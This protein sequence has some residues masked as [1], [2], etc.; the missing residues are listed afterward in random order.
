[1]NIMKRFIYSILFIGVM[2]ITASCGKDWLSDLATNPNQPSEAPVQLLLPPLL[3]NYAAQIT[4]GYQSVGNWMGYYA[5]SGAYSIDFNTYTYY[6]TYTN[7]D[8][9]FW[10]RQ[11]KNA[12]YI[13]QQSSGQENME[14]FVAVAKILKAFGYQ[15]LVDSYNEAPYSKAFEGSNDFFPTYDAGQDIYNINIAQLDSAIMVIQ[16]AMANNPNAIALGGNDIMFQGDMGQW[17]KFANTLKLR[18]LIRESNVI[19]ATDAQ[20]EISKTAAVGY[21]DGDALVNPGYLNTAQKQNP[22][23]ATMGL[24]AGGSLYSD[25]YSYRFAGG[26]LVNFFK[27]YGDPRLFY[28]YSPGGGVDPTKSSYMQV[29]STFS[30]YDAAYY[31][32]RDQSIELINAGGG[33]G[34]GHGVMKGFDASVPVIS[35]AES[36][37]MQAEAV[38][39]GWMTGD[40]EKLF[41]NGITA[42]FEYLGVVG[43]DDAAEAYYTNGKVLSDWSATPANRRI[44][45][46]ITQKWVST[47]ISDNYEAWAEY[48]RTGF[49]TAAILPLSKYP[50]NTRHIP[51]K[52][53]FPKSE[54]DRNQEAYKAAVANGND[55]Q[56]S[57]I[58]WM[59]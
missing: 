52:Y 33:S 12:N 47:A 35:A 15:Y 27:N 11:L 57:M 55:P 22:L 41:D 7:G 4:S 50:G 42:S 3:S 32:N 9:D 40:A 46:I 14:N 5:Y 26:A 20:S 28:V 54:S 29:D 2:S 13:E 21:L 24:T 17:M 10:F 43:A 18:Y 51:T 53:M 59:K 48:R 19:S 39:R 37:F 34:I 45:A 36:Y 6:L 56:S 58:F 8:W 49:P 16:N 44:E 25:G 30:D 38:Q 23:W 1:M 31:G